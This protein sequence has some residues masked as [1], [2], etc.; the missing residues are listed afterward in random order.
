MRRRV[1]FGMVTVVFVIIVALLVY[2]GWRNEEVNRQSIA[3]HD[4]SIKQIRIAYRKLSDGIRQN[5]QARNASVAR[6]NRALEVAATANANGPKER[7][8]A[9]V[10]VAPF[11]LVADNCSRYP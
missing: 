1:P 11:T 6:F 9:L 10:K 2:I 7:K 8:A 4:D 3:R 5:C